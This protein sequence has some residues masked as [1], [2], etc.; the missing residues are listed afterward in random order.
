MSTSAAPTYLHYKLRLRS[1]A[2]VSTL[3]GDPNS[4]AT[5]PFIPGGALR[6]VLA[7]RLLASGVGGDTEEFRRLILSGDVRYLH[8][9]PEL[10]GERSLP[11]PASW[12]CRK[13]D[14]R[15]AFDLAAYS[16]TISTDE[17]PD[18]FDW[19][20]HALAG[21]GDPF[22]AASG[23]AGTTIKPYLG[24]RLHQQRDREKGRPWTKRNGRSE[25]RRGVIFPV[26]Y[27]EADQVFRGAIQIMP[28]ATADIQ[29]VE[30]LLRAGPILVG[31][32]RRAGYGGEAAVE[33]RTQAQREYE[34]VSD[35]IS[36]DVDADAWFR[37]LL[38]SAYVGRHP[39]TGQI[40][41]SALQHELERRLDETAKVKRTRWAFETVGAF[42]QKWRVEVPQAQ[43]VA[44]GAVLVLKATRA[45][46][47]S[48]LRAIEH[49]GLG[50]RRV[51]G[52]GRILFLEHLDDHRTFEIQGE[53]KDREHSGLEQ[54]L[55]PTAHEREHISLLERRIVLAA[56][57]SELDQIATADIAAKSKTLPSSS[58]LGRLRTLFRG[59]VNEGS[60]ETALNNLATWCSTGDKALKD[61]ARKR[62][63][64][65]NVPAGTLLNWLTALAAGATGESAWKAL[66]AAVGNSANR[67]NPIAQDHCLTDKETAQECLHAHA[68]QLCVYLIDGVLVALARR[69][70]SK[71]KREETSE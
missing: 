62:L 55:A 32:S 16:G 6:G 57:R 8:A 21:V 44:G 50:E 59:V 52:F 12:K 40:D 60:A 66:L 31:R 69:N 22:S 63:E 7:A 1:P 41:P 10:A 37:A 51:E 23:A 33:F 13:D 24:S 65:C 42:N 9:Y 58:L 64:K 27:V 11:C 45:I 71:G 35:S 29:C 34:N 38:T 39:A 43:A 61:K 30:E 4:A 46:P 70:R 17:D 18:D 14:N 5:Q 49:E 3:S 56:A 26:E 20:Q 54:V 53:R 25:E 2:I 15:S 47:V 67:L 36:R 48:T 28:A 19:P 68:A